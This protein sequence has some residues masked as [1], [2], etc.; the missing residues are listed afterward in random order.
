MNEK[1]TF[2]ILLTFGLIFTTPLLKAQQVND[3]SYTVH[4]S[5]WDCLEKN[6]NSEAIIKGV[7][8]KYTPNKTGKGAN[9]MFWD[10][11]I[12]LTDS[13]AVPVKSTN[14]EI[15]YKYFEDKNVLIKGTI[16][17]GIIIGSSEG[18]NATG[19]RIDPV[20]IEIQGNNYSIKEILTSKNFTLEEDYVGDWGGHLHTF[21]FTVH[22]KDLRIQWKNPELLKNGKDLD[23]LLPMS[24][25]DTLENIFIKCS[26][27]IKT[28][29]NGSTEHII[30][31]FTNKNITYI[32]DDRF[33]MECND[34]FKA[35]KEALLSEWEK[36]ENK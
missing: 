27:R 31:K 28:S 26:E 13:F 20:G 35:W 2:L 12:L 32:I 14:N 11:E 4:C 3:K 24:V 29:K 17:Y 30:Y 19:F 22:G 23:V 10:W 9:Y 8:R 16:F 25:L 34:D 6:K 36:Q 1:N 7:F 21:T 5:T 18:Q 15:N 33:S